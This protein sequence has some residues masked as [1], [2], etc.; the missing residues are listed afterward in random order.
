MRYERQQ[1]CNFLPFAHSTS[2]TRHIYVTL[3]Q[4]YV[5]VTLVGWS[6]RWRRQPRKF[7][8]WHQNADITPTPGR[9]YLDA[10]SHDHLN[11]D[12]SVPTLTLTP[13]SLH[14]DSDTKTS[15][16]C[17]N[18]FLVM[19]YLCDERNPPVTFQIN[20]PNY[21]TTS[22]LLPF[23]DREVRP[24]GRKVKVRRGKVMKILWSRVNQ[25]RSVIEKR[26]TWWK[27]LGSRLF[28]CL[29]VCMC[30]CSC[31]CSC[32]C[33]YACWSFSEYNTCANLVF[34]CVC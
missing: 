3:K 31:T 26:E 2:R 13:G 27:I 15:I 12:K 19:Q 20:P 30:T 23:I 7:W 16:Q 34:V 28:V 24:Q 21:P 14:Q 32:S 6:R 25:K 8:R 1:R 17:V 11:A 10:D 4:C 9:R 22:F 18:A 29:H 5:G 33:M